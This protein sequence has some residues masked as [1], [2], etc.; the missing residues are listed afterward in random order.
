MVG[1]RR[2]ALFSVFAAS[3]SSLSSC[4]G[5]DLSEQ[6]GCNQVY[7]SLCNKFYDCYSKDDLAA[8]KDIFGLNRGDCAV[9]YQNMNCTPTMVACDSGQT[10]HPDKAQSCLAGFKSLSCSDIMMTPLP[11]PAVCDQICQ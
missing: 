2:L 11:T 7:A 4:G 3:I 5:S 10:Y 9:K 6:E 8:N 1:L